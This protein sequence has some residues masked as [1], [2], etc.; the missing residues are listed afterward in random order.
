MSY[1]DNLITNS[2]A[3]TGDTTGWSAS[4]TSVA[5]GG[6]DG[7]YC[8]E[9]SDSGSLAQTV[10][11]SRQPL[12]FLFSA[13]YLPEFEKSGAETE[14]KAL[15]KMTYNFSDGSQAKYNMPLIVNEES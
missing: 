3:E 1:S 14:I 10:T 6:T 9:M 15:V 13:N 2:G 5:P 12:D 7:S 4:N 11:P 8:F